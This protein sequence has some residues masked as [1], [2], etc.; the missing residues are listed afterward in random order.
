M[1][2]HSKPCDE[3]ENSPTPI[4]P[5][6]GAE[7]TEVVAHKIQLLLTMMVGSPQDPYLPS[8]T[9]QLLGV[10]LRAPDLLLQT[11]LSGSRPWA[12]P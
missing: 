3:R 9:G 8:C 6:S 1:G 12:I 2:A 7:G 11:D 5:A 10:A 4:R